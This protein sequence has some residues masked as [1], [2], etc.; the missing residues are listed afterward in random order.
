MLKSVVAATLAAGIVLVSSPALAEPISQD[1]AIFAVVDRIEGDSM[2]LSALHSVESPD[3]ENILFVGD[4]FR[5][6]RVEPPYPS[7]R[8]WW[9]VMAIL[10]QQGQGAAQ[11]VPEG[12]AHQQCYAMVHT[13]RGR[14]GL[15]VAA[16]DQVVWVMLTGDLLFVRGDDDEAVAK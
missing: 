14:P 15:E 4:K 1:T 3:L 7:D 9:C 13:F 6:K 2:T 16:I 10:T 8:Q 11:L 5:A 12:S